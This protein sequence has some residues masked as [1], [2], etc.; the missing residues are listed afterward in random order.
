MASDAQCRWRARTG[1]KSQNLSG[2]IRMTWWRFKSCLFARSELV[3]SACPDLLL[4]SRVLQNRVTLRTVLVS[5]LYNLSH[6]DLL[7]PY[8]PERFC[9][10]AWYGMSRTPTSWLVKYRWTRSTRTPTFPASFDPTHYLG[11]VHLTEVWEVYL[12]F[13]GRKTSVISWSWSLLHCRESRSP[14][15]SPSMN[16]SDSRCIDCIT[17][18]H[19]S[20]N[21]SFHCA[22]QL[23]GPKLR[24]LTHTNILS[25]WS[26]TA[27][28]AFQVLAVALDPA[29][30]EAAVVPSVVD[31]PDLP[32]RWKRRLLRKL[33][34]DSPPGRTLHDLPMVGSQVRKSF[35]LSILRETKSTQ[36]TGGCRPA[37]LE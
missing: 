22:R 13:R 4:V 7:H 28:R 1:L 26:D 35:L 29:P 33:S 2:E 11:T 10:Q 19:S 8:I 3:E 34:G 31:E 37:D 5:R 20:W 14:F 18:W 21:M 23:F 25:A 16:R 32:K 17:R 27:N 30:E 9:H 36:F 24:P 12:D 15:M 6:D